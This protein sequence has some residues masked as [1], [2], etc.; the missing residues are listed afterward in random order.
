MKKRVA[1]FIASEVNAHQVK[2]LAVA[3]KRNRF[4]PNLS[5]PH[6][7]AG[8]NRN[9][10]RRFMAEMIPKARLAV[11]VLEQTESTKIGRVIRN[12]NKEKL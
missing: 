4:L 10:K 12:I 7:R 9:W 11:E 6:P 1:S 2:R 3:I 8:R 5:A